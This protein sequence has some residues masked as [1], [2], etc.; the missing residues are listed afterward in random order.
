MILHQAAVL[1]VINPSRVVQE[2]HVSAAYAYTDGPFLQRSQHRV[3]I[4]ASNFA[5]PRHKE[6]SN[7]TT[8]LQQCCAI[9][10]VLIQSTIS[11]VRSTPSIL[12]TQSRS[13][14]TLRIIE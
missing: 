7:V 3:F 8:A 5:L 13:Q 9:A 2:R 6:S 11:I 4:E 12:Q 14:V 1:F 10:Q